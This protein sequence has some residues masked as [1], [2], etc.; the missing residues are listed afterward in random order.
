MT[1]PNPPNL[2]LVSLLGHNLYAISKPS[3]II[4]KRSI[5][6]YVISYS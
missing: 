3:L 1:F 2:K 6:V 5:G 4:L